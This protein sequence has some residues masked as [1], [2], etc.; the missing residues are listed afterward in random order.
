MRSLDAFLYRS[1]YFRKSTFE[2]PWPFPL[3]L[4][5]PEPAFRLF[6][7]LFKG[8]VPKVRQVLAEHSIRKE[9]VG[10]ILI[11]LQKLVSQA[12]TYRY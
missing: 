1:D 8:L 2:T 11:W 6:G 12:G 5:E 7:S 4:D 3:Q 10:R 9:K